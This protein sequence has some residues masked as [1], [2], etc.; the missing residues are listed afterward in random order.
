MCILGDYLMQPYLFASYDTCIG[1]EE[2]NELCTHIPGPACA[3]SSGNSNAG[4]GEGY[5]HPHRGIHGIGNISAAVYDWA[6]P[7]A[8]VYMEEPAIV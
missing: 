7:V 8:V 6:N 5:I 4:P 3:D 2:N 1:T